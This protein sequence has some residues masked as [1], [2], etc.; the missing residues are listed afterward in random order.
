MGSHKDHFKDNFGKTSWV[1]MDEI[2]HLPHKRRMQKEIK[3]CSDEIQ[4][5]IKEKKTWKKKNNKIFNSLND[6][7]EA[8]NFI[9]YIYVLIN[10]HEQL[11]SKDRKKNIHAN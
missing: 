10:Y 6:F 3:Y 1:E 9:L 8:F 4:P 11:T 2:I 7:L 5:V